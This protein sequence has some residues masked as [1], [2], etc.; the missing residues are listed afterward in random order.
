ML[1]S[2]EE[3]PTPRHQSH[4]FDVRCQLQ[5][6]QSIA[7]Q[8]SKKGEFAGWESWNGFMMAVSSTRAC[9]VTRWLLATRSVPR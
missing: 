8:Q 2:S 5:V 4:N 1:L 6:G 3:V 7:M 9:L